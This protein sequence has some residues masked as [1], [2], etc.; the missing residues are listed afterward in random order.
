MNESALNALR[1]IVAFSAVVEIVT[2]IA[3][4]IAPAVIA[5]MLVRAEVT[6]LTI[7]L[8]RCMG[9]G[10]LALGFGCW[11]GS[12]R[13]GP[14]SAAFRAILTYNALI[15]LVLGGVGAVAHLAGPL[16][17]PAVALHGAVAL[18]LVWIRR[19]QEHWK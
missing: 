19:F 11:R 7:L 17:W 6:D 18:A 2:G 1:R 16:L 15:A 9:V 5:A 10:L 4:L 14:G 8:A 3:L 13:A 12:R